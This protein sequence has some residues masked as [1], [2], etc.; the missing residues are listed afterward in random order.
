[1]SP[2]KRKKSCNTPQPLVSITL[3]TSSP[4]AS[5]IATMAMMATM[6]PTVEIPIKLET[7][8]ERKV[9]RARLLMILE[10]ELGRG[11]KDFSILIFEYALPCDGW[12]RW[13][14]KCLAG[15]SSWSGLCY[16]CGKKEY[17]IHLAIHKELLVSSSSPD[18]LVTIARIKS[19]LSY[20]KPPLARLK[21][22]IVAGLNENRFLSPGQLAVLLDNV[23][24]IK[25]DRNRIPK[26]TASTAMLAVLCLCIPFDPECDEHNSLEFSRCNP[27]T[28]EDGFDQCAIA[29]A[30]SIAF[31]NYKSFTASKLTDYIAKGPK[32]AQHL[33]WVLAT[34]TREARMRCYPADDTTSI[35]ILH[36]LIS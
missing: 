21:E 18:C 20:G 30:E 2:K 7:A 9:Y 4:L 12:W 34:I 22:L 29:G 28:F 16:E 6:G 14:R 5:P 24:P 25:I 11:F 27:Q 32:N 15:Y 8:H 3:T 19:H 10:E 36:T 17:V 33:G 31:E 13:C 26:F 1:M 23:C 35:M